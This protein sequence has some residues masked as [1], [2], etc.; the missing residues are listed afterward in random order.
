MAFACSSYNAPRWAA[1]AKRCLVSRMFD[2]VSRS[3]WISAEIAPQAVGPC[4]LTTTLR[5]SHRPW[6]H[7]SIWSRAA[8]RS[9]RASSRSLKQE[10]ARRAVVVSDHPDYQP[11]WDPDDDGDSD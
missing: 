1:D 2:V 4:C 10:V 7:S 6:R 11:E 3:C 9:A 8:S 5:M